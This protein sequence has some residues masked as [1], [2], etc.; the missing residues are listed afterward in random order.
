M[1]HIGPNE[2]TGVER[3]LG[4]EAM[5]TTIVIGAIFNLQFQVG[6]HPAASWMQ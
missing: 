3:V 5:T 2:S 6:A 4:Q 1:T